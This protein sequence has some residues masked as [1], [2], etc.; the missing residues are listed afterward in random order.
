ME[1]I[2]RRAHAEMFGPAIS[3]RLQLADTDLMIEVEADYTLR[4]GSYG[5]EVKFGGTKTIRDAMA[6]SQRTN[7]EV[8]NENST[9]G[10]VDTI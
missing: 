7:A 4:S 6:Q 2:G 9:G 10:A 5:K 1:T 3:D 8:E